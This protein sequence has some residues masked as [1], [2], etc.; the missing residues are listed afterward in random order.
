MDTRN[1]RRLRVSLTA[2]VG[3]VAMIAMLA[4]VPAASAAKIS[5]GKTVLQPK[6]STFEALA[7]AG[8]TVAPSGDARANANGIVFPITGGRANPAAPNAKIK[9]DGGLTFSG[10]GTAVTLQDYIVR[11]GKKNV[12]DS[13]VAGGGGAVR[14]A[15]L[16]LGKAKIKEKGGR[17]IVGKVKVKLARKAAKALSATFGLPNLTGA[18]LGKATVKIVP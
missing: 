11:I 17:V 6:A 2:G 3:A 8:V 5:G 14:L 10:A 18:P 9:H 16:G 12:I 4:F 13:H 15:D 7:D 1:T